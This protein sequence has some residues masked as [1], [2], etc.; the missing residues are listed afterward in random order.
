MFTGIKVDAITASGNDAPGLPGSIH[1][2]K[3]WAIYGVCS[4]GDVLLAMVAQG[5]V[6]PDALLRPE[7]VALWEHVT[8]R[9][10][11]PSGVLRQT[12]P[13]SLEAFSRSNLSQIP[14]FRDFLTRALTAIELTSLAGGVT[15]VREWGIF[16][17]DNGKY[18][19]Y[20]ARDKL[21]GP[22]C[23]TERLARKVPI[24]TSSVGSLVQLRLNY[25]SAMPPEN[26]EDDV[27]RECA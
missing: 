19:A 4:A 5:D 9:A 23:N 7:M 25:L 2:V 11:T 18:A 17:S 12:G 16:K 8:L 3:S 15:P 6:L 21:M 24:K 10:M 22:V 26:S 20:S 1:G 27:G 13:Y 14:A